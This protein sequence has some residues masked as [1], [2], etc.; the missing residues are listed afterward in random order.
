MTNLRN[1]SLRVP[2]SWVEYDLRNESLA[3]I[4]AKLLS[5]AGEEA[6]KEQVN[7]LFRKAREVLTGA[8]ERGAIY[9]AGAFQMYEDGLLLANTMIFAVNPSPGRP[10]TLQDMT[11]QLTRGEP[12][13]NRSVTTVTLPEVGEVGRVT[14][15]EEVMIDEDF[16]VKMLVMH[17]IVPIPDDERV[18]IVTCT[19]PNLPLAEQLFDLF[20]AISSTFR[21]TEP[22]ALAGS[23]A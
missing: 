18:L 23:K 22:A 16:G 12:D 17:T 15:T 4:R 21:F 14:G 1:F 8:K 2:E 3:A 19:S 20:D 6:T 11:R 7:T 9:A 10:I 13:P 5:Q